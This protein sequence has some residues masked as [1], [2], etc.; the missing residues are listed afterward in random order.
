MAVHHARMV[1]RMPCLRSLLAA[2]VAA[3]AL[4]GCQSTPEPTTA[5]VGPTGD[6][7]HSTPVYCYR[8]LGSV[9]CY[10]EPLPGP[11][12]RLVGGYVPQDDVEPE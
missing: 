7:V 6:P 10:R 5:L 2:G 12:N 11:P 3:L 9:D 8:T 1:Y 4:A